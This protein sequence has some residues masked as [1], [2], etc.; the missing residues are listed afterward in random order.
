MGVLRRGQSVPPLH[1]VMVS[2]HVVQATPEAIGIWNKIMASTSAVELGNLEPEQDEPR[3]TGPCRMRD[4]ARSMRPMPRP[5]ATADH[6]KPRTPHHSGARPE[7]TDSRRAQHT[8][9]LQKSPGES[10]GRILQTR[11]RL[12]LS[13][14]QSELTNGGVVD[15]YCTRCVCAPSFCAVVDGHAMDAGAVCDGSRAAAAQRTSFS[16]PRTQAPTI[17]YLRRVQ[18]IA[19]AAGRRCSIDSRCRVPRCG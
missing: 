4:R 19:D 15:H 7:H 8:S 18:R 6:Q 17:F 5:S 14:A 1:P 3:P 16:L 10:V 13:T 12:P 2:L 11:K 9:H